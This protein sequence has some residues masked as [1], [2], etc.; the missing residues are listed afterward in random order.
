MHIVSS[1]S[2]CKKAVQG[3]TKK[4][5]ENSERKGVI[6]RPTKNGRCLFFD[7]KTKLENGRNSSLPQ[8]GRAGASH[9][10]CRSFTTVCVA[11]DCT[12][13]GF[14]DLFWW[15]LG[16]SLLPGRRRLSHQGAG[17]HSKVR[18]AILVP[19]LLD[20][21]AR[22]AERGLEHGRGLCLRLPRSRRSL[23]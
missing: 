22:V 19:D 4:T 13:D 7:G 18:F 15:R 8:R 12:L 2:L 9:S 23:L 11:A 1:S 3:E 17:R 16:G 20:V 5:K 6:D 21:P 14:L 10:L